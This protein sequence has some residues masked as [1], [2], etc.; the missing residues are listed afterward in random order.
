MFGDICLFVSVLVRLW[1]NG[2][3]RRRETF[4]IDEQRLTGH[5]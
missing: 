3:C 2:G 1:E 5:A 4:R